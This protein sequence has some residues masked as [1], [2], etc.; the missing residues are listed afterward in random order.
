MVDLKEPHPLNIFREMRLPFDFASLPLSVVNLNAAPRGDGHPVLVLPGYLADDS[1]TWVIRA[2]LDYLGYDVSGW[3]LGLNR[4][5]V[6]KSKGAMI[7]RLEQIVEE[8]GQSVRLVGQSLGGVVSREIARERPY[9]V[10]RIV[11]LGSPVVG[12]P[13]YTTISSFFR[14]LTGEDVDHIEEIIKQRERVPITTPI[15]AIY[16]RSDGVVSWQACI[17]ENNPNVDH[18]EV[19]SSHGGMGVNGV[20]LEIIAK[21]LAP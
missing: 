14:R 17:D 21:T 6:G 3:G 15:T 10:D 19:A 12:G 20:V 5:G 1:S 7:D 11:T 16:S 9:L 13:K 8:T 18:V 4:G 2:Y